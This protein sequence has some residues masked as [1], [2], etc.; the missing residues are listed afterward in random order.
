M[1]TRLEPRETIIA[2]E[3]QS[4]AMKLLDRYGPSRFVDAVEASRFNRVFRKRFNVPL[5]DDG[6]FWDEVQTSLT[7]RNPAASEPDNE[8]LPAK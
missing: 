4:K 6:S 7:Q 8:V 3:D 5:S 2:M 1:E